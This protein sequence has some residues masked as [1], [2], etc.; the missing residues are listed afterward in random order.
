[1]KKTVLIASATFDEHAFGPVATLLEQKGYPV[2]V[3]LTDRLLSGEDRFTI[4]LCNA[5]PAILYNERSIAPDDLSA[6]WFRKIGSFGIADVETQLAKQLY[7]NN[8]VRALHDT[9][10]SQFYPEEVWLSSPAKLA[11]ADR[12]LGQLVLARQVGFNVP[13]TIVSSDWDKIS[14]TLITNNNAKIIVKMMRGIISEGAQ[15]KALHTTILDQQRIDSLKGYT[16]P[17]PGLYQPLVQKAREWRVTV[18]GED[19][20]PVAIYTAES[21]KDDWR[22]HQSSDAVKFKRGELPDE[23]AALCIAYLRAT[24][25]RFGAFDFAERPTG[26]IVFL[27]C[28]PNGQYGWAE[29]ELNFP[30]S[31]SIASELI[32]IGRERG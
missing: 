3:Y 1:M 13:E 11:R 15:I 19:V 25:L 30:I 27:E 8:E 2:V 4:D 10:W 21:A 7:L 29:E 16:S 26:E 18:V 31:D 17:F 32:R 14:S 6:A 23:I 12:K 22:K 9:I 24:G 28:N 5:V 20:F